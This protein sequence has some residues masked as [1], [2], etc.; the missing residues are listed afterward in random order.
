MPAM[1]EDEILTGETVDDTEALDA[2]VQEDDE[3]DESDE[4][5]SEEDTDTDSDDADSNN[6]DS[7]DEADTDTQLTPKE[8][9]AFVKRLEAEKRKWEAEKQRDLESKINPYKR[10]VDMLGGDPAIVEQAIQQNQLAAQARRYADEY[11]WDDQQT[12]YY[13]QQEQAKQATSR[14]E[15]ELRELRLSNEINDLRDNKEFPGIIAMKKQIAEK[16]A[17][18]NGALTVAEAYWALG[19]QGRAKQMTREAEQRE[20]MKRRQGKRVISNDSPNSA[21]MEKAIPANILAEGRRLKMSEQEIR[22][23]MAF[24]STNIDDYRA[25]K[26]KK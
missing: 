19:G 4:V 22:E 11:G 3:I 10:I 15:Q 1:E 12:Q 16:V 2:E 5:N 26:S 14:M 21:S 18:A 25:K 7:D 24:D 8:Q 17:K 6:D 13:I 9:N 23:L 20:A